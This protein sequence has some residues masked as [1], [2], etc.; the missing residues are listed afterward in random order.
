MSRRTSHFNMANETN[1][2]VILS[3]ARSGSTW[4][5]DMLKSMDNT[6]AYGELFLRVARKQRTWFNGS[7]DY[8]RFIER[9]SK[10]GEFRPF[11]VFSYLDS[12]YNQPGTVGFKLMYAQLCFYPEIWFY[13]WRHRIRIVHLVRLNH[14]DVLISRELVQIRQKAHFL[15]GQEPGRMKIHLD[16]E[17]V[18]RRM[19]KLRRNI[20]LARI[21]L[22]WFRLSHIEVIYEELVHAPLSFDSIWDFLSINT[23]RRT[24]TSNLR[25][26]RKDEQ[27]GVISN[28]EEVKRAL[29]GTAFANVLN[30]TNW[31]SVRQ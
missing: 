23:E 4:L 8:P 24:P 22:R 7:L 27:A 28:Y 12:L 6:E 13:L 21:L 16:P 18:F 17:M 2:F 3:S 10:N 25:K 31:D 14:L 26:I 19:K 20:L 9:Q 29:E 15:A 11:S 1:N 5:V 30:C